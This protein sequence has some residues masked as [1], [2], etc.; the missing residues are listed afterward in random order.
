VGLEIVEIVM[1]AEETFGISLPDAR[2]S[3]LH[4]VGELHECIVDVLGQDQDETSLRPIVLERLE[5]ALSARERTN[6][7]M[8][9][10]RRSRAGGGPAAA[11]ACEQAVAHGGVIDG[12]M[13]LSSLFPFAG[14]RETWA[15]FEKALG[16]PLPPL[17]RP[18]LVRAILLVLA[19]FLG[20][21]GGLAAMV[22]LLPP[23]PPGWLGAPLGVLFSA[24]A[25]YLSWR[26]N[27][28]LTRPLARFWP[29]GLHSVGDLADFVMQQHYGKVVKKEQGFS[30]DEVWCILQDIVAGVLRVDRQRVTPEARFAEDLGAG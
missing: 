4:T 5:N 18:R 27:N 1:D 12:G 28:W 10:L 9:L 23:D 20:W 15:R 29:R 7:S 8:P 17:E 25:I 21:I 3:G 2:V 22:V 11:A 14:R 6:D 30:R 26:L 24:V 19:V 16:L 13:Q